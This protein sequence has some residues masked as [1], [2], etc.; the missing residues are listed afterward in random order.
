MSGSSL[1][2]MVTHA[3]V[4]SAILRCHHHAGCTPQPLPQL[5]GILSMHQ[6][7]TLLQNSTKHCQQVKPSPTTK[8]STTWSSR[9][10]K[11]F[12]TPM[13][14]KQLSMWSESLATLLIVN[15][16][17][18]ST[19]SL[20]DLKRHLRRFRVTPGAYT[21]DKFP[22][23]SSYPTLVSQPLARRLHW[24]HRRH[25]RQPGAHNRRGLHPAQSPHSAGGI[26]SKTMTSSRL[27]I[28]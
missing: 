2:K 22:R 14:H 28:T 3:Q 24:Q 12:R 23:P 17:G 25:L 20:A 1:P 21:F 27:H 18:N 16:H 8:S 15:H 5:D 26:I 13:V 7:G 9:A 10:R 19:R 6:R 4:L 11:V